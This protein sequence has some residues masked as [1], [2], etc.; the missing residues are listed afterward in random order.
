MKSMLLQKH[1]R[2]LM[3][4]VISAMAT[5]C[6]G[7]ET[8]SS[9]GEYIDDSVITAKVKTALLNSP[10]VSGLSIEVETF[11]GEVQLSGFVDSSDERGE[12]EKLAKTVPGVRS[13]KNDIRVK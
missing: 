9:T 7:N 13:V 4:I 2:V 1:L 10:K 11:R 8:K 5:A 3:L 6:A 12:A